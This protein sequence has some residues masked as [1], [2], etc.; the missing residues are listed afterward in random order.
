ML[1]LLFF[2]RDASLL[3]DRLAESRARRLLLPG[4][5]QRQRMRL[6]QLAADGQRQAQSREQRQR[7][8]R[9]AQQAA[10][11]CR[12]AHGLCSSAEALASPHR[13]GS[14]L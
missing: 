8:P 2:M 5:T 11:G 3:E 1:H 7:R 13:G 10:R 14:L 12:A 4:R 9:Q 6:R